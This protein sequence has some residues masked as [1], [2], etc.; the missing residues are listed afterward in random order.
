MNRKLIKPSIVLGVLFSLVAIVAACSKLFAISPADSEKL[1]AGFSDV[2]VPLEVGQVVPEYQATNSD[3][4]KVRLSD[5]TDEQPALLLFYRGDWCPFCMDQ[6]DGI[7]AVLPEIQEQGVQVIAVSPD[8]VATTE[9][10]RR[11][12]GQGFLFW[13]DKE[14]ENMSQFGIDREDGLPHPSVFL[15]AKGGKLVWFYASED[16]KQRPTG[17]QLLQVIKSKL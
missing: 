17:E 15:I 2:E 16:Y 11:Q 9:N 7:K 12:F 10:T 14:T 13:S 6:L 4:D 3:G 1:N 5:V 8:D